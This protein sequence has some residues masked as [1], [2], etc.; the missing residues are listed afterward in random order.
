MLRKIDTKGVLTSYSG[1]CP[2]YYKSPVY[3]PQTHP[4]K[5]GLSGSGYTENLIRINP[6]ARPWARPAGWRRGSRQPVG[7]DY[8][9]AVASGR[10]LPA[11]TPAWGPHLYVLLA[12]SPKLSIRKTR[13]FAR[14]RAFFAFARQSST[15]SPRYTTECFA[16]GHFGKGYFPATAPAHLI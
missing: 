6:D 9:A 11:A 5:Y 1:P 16:Q 2:M 7:S 10:P 12:G 8:Q 4:M 3:I 14:K 15:V 13:Y